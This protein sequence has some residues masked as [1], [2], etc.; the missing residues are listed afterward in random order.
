VSSLSE[1]LLAWADRLDANCIR[2]Q[3][4]FHSLSEQRAI[5]REMRQAAEDALPYCDI[6]GG[7][8]RDGCEVDVCRDC[9]DFARYGVEMLRN[10][11]SERSKFATF[12][13]FGASCVAIAAAIDDPDPQ[14]G[15]LNLRLAE[16]VALA[17][18]VGEFN[19]VSLPDS[20][21]S[22][23]K[24]LAACIVLG[25]WARQCAAT[26]NRLQNERIGGGT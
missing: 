3:T 12:L 9:Y 7:P 26:H 15:A 17:A 22:K 11:P 5:A 18:L 10:N 25:R 21:D 13:N 8:H 23:D 20:E 1:S 16:S 14:I 24:L 2:L 4:L 6:C 19:V